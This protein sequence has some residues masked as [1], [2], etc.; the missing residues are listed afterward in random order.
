MIS[1]L[2]ASLTGTKSIKGTVS[3][4]GYTSFEAPWGGGAMGYAIVRLG[5]PHFQ[6][7]TNQWILL[8]FALKCGY[9]GYRQ[10]TAQTESKVKHAAGAAAGFFGGAFLGYAYS[11]HL[12]HKN[13][14]RDAPSAP[15]ARQR[16]EY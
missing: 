13:N 7:T 10:A 8:L 6:L 3:E 12:E 2:E 15:Q 16:L 14:T 1:Q 9:S 4:A 11:R 5:S